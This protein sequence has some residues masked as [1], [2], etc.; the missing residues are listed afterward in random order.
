MGA[1]AASA[2]KAVAAAPAQRSNSRREKSFD[3]NGPRFF[4]N[5]FSLKTNAWIQRWGVSGVRNALQNGTRRKVPAK[6]CKEDCGRTR[7]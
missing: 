1:A 6:R 5:I 3:K 2:L 7:G 4:F